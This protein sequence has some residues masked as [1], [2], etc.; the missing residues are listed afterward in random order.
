M[1]EEK[2][3]EVGELVEV[4]SKD[5]TKSKVK[6]KVT[7]IIFYF[8]QLG[9][10]AISSFVGFL[11]GLSNNASNSYPYVGFNPSYIFGPI[12]VAIIH[13]GNLGMYYRMSK[14]NRLI[15]KEGTN[16]KPLPFHIYPVVF[17]NIL[18]S[19]FCFFSI[20]NAMISGYVFTSTTDY[21]VYT[22]KKVGIYNK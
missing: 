18:L 21:G 6:K 8:I 7:L 1:N 20:Y 5:I 17:L 3:N 9:F 16:D 12:I 4:D 11:F 10:L 15:M 13:G 14:N 19:V 2:L 22:R